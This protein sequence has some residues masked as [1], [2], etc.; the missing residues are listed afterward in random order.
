[1][2]RF[3]WMSV[4]FLVGGISAILLHFIN[5]HVEGFP[6]EVMLV[7]LPADYFWHE[8]QGEA[9]RGMLNKLVGNVAVFGILAGL[10]GAL[11]GVILDLYSFSRQ[12]ALNRRVKYLR[13]GTDKMDLAFQRRVLE[14]LTRHDPGGLI[15]RGAA[16]DSY[17]SE[18]EMILKRLTKLGSPR[19]L[20]KFC[21]QRFRAKFG[22]RVAGNFKEYDSLAAQIWSA[23]GRQQSLDRQELSVS[24]GL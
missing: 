2:I 17:A 23:Y 22:W 7:F 10:E 14:I 19:G 24:K 5:K 11:V 15:K 13:G 3:R 20:R 18:A 16:K 6:E 1:M 21:R 8:L 4:L 12:S 9:G